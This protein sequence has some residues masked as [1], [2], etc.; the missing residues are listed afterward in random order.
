MRGT[1]RRDTSGRLVCVCSIAFF[2]AASVLT[3]SGQAL[4]GELVETE[5]KE[6]GDIP[7]RSAA[8]VVVSPDGRRLAVPVWRD[9]GQVVICDGKAGPKCDEV[10]NLTFS[11]NG[12]VLIYAASKNNVWFVVSGRKAG[13]TH[14]F[15][16]GPSVSYNGRCVAYYASGEGQTGTVFVN[17]A[18]QKG[19]KAVSTVTPVVSRSGRVAF[20]ARATGTFDKPLPLGSTG[21]HRNPVWGYTDTVNRTLYMMCDRKR[22]QLFHDLRTP[23]FSPDSAHL[24]YAAR[25][26]NKWFIICDKDKVSEALNDV[27]AP[28]WSPNSRKL[29]Y[30][31]SVG[32]RWFVV[33]GRTKYGP[34][35]EVGVMAF[36]DR[37]SHLG[38]AA[39][40]GGQWTL[41]CDGKKGPEYDEIHWVGFSKNERHLACAVEKGNRWMMVVDGVEA[42]GHDQIYVPEQA[43]GARSLC[44]VAVDDGKARCVEVSWPTETDWTNGL[45]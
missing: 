30:A 4:A 36:S 20:S 24:A 19:P 41:F 8:G 33:S 27:S 16:M 17:G 1:E 32:G 37:G 43:G 23:V 10:K 39:R 31:A 6:L 26:E 25:L 44:Y 29:A 34:F 22:G 38:F 15:L 9:G 42:P 11:G 2:L 45:E 12:R 28:V 7:D 40:T 13:P 21:G 5:V 18:P 14:P 3:G 35:G